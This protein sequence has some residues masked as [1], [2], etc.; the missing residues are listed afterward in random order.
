MKCF[1]K[2]ERTMTRALFI[3]SIILAA[4]LFVGSIVIGVVLLNNSYE[5]QTTTHG[6]EEVL[7]I[8]YVIHGI[9]CVSVYPITIIFLW[10][11]VVSLIGYFRDIKK[12]RYH[13]V[14]NK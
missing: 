9:L 10:L 11:L 13:L 6:P 3:V 4:I 7:N 2:F 8:Y 12:I 14:D 5:V 1:S